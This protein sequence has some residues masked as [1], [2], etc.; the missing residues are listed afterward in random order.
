MFVTV[1]DRYSSDRGVLTPEQRLFY[2]ENGFLL[3]KDLVSDEDI[4]RFRYTLRTLRES[5]WF[6]K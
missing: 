6:E 4:Q 1:W 2:E 3:I 5:T